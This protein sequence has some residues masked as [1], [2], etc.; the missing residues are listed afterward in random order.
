MHR[1][2]FLVCIY[3]CESTSAMIIAA[4]GSSGG[5]TSGRIGVLA[6]W[7]LEALGVGYFIIETGPIHIAHPNL[8]ADLTILHFVFSVPR[9]SASMSARR[10]RAG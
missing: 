2:S 3:S 9:S 6:R 10:K 4:R 1:V 7:R 8:H 5:L